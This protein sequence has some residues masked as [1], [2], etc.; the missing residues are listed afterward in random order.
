MSVV[1]DSVIDITSKH[2]GATYMLP[3]NDQQYLCR[4]GGSGRGFKH[5][6]KVKTNNLQQITK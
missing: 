3:M 5:T 2:V 6:V 1:T 4:R